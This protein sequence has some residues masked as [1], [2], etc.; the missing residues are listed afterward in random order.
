MYMKNQTLFV[1]LNINSL[2]KLI[3]E[4]VYWGG[5]FQNKISKIKLVFCKRKIK[6]TWTTKINR[7]H[8]VYDYK[9]HG[10]C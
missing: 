9:I 4:L 3:Q 6:Q 7:V 8:I 10:L 2:Q 1:K 5:G